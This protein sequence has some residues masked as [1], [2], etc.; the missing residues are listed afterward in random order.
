MK[1]IKSF[2]D[3]QNEEC[4]IYLDIMKDFFVGRR[5][6][7]MMNLSIEQL[8]SILDSCKEYVDKNQYVE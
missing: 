8:E 7:K 2:K 1:K 3:L 4:E 5:S 6:A